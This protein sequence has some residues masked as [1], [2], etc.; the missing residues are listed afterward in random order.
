LKKFSTLVVLSALTAGL[1]VL[2]AEAKRL[3]GGAN[4]GKQRSSQAMREA[5]R[6]TPKS[7]T[8][9]QQATPAPAA[10]VAGAAAGAGAAAAAKPS[11]MSR[12]GGMIAG[13]GAGALLASMF[14]GSL[15]GL[16]Q[17]MGGILNILLIA[18]ALYLAYRFFMSRR[19]PAAA[20]A[21]GMQ[22]A[23]AG[24]GN[25]SPNN[26]PARF[27]RSLP[28]PAP[29]F[30]QQPQA[31]VPADIAVPPGFEIEPF[32][33]QAQSSFLRLQA[34][35]DARD[36]A[37]IRDT[38]TPEV[39]AEL[40]MQMRERGDVAQKTEIVTL[41]ARL[42]EVVTEGD[43]TIASLRYSGLVRESA[44]AAALPFNE[45]WHLRSTGSTNGPWLIAGIQQLS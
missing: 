33:R 44:D 21:G 37:D 31:A 3:G 29:A 2:P 7:N 15:G 22:F 24:G 41:D 6:E 19:R 32:V 35:N 11:F 8:A 28:P 9:Q 13:L 5:P 12:Y 25:F 1:A 4:L 10:P 23:G 26:E 36:L 18:G 45:V 17:A 40:A 42:L 30:E 16:G 34:A 14:G 39:Y 20:G 38:T 27:E 43:H